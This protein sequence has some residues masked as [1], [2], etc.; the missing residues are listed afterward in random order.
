MQQVTALGRALLPLF[1]VALAGAP[2]WLGQPEWQWL[3]LPLMAL[4]IFWG[5]GIGPLRGALT[6]APTAPVTPSPM[7]QLLERLL[8]TW[9]HHV[10]SA[11]RQT[12]TAIG[13][14]SRSLAN[15][16]PHM[17]SSGTGPDGIAPDMM[18]ECGNALNAVSVSLRAM[19]QQHDRVLADISALAERTDALTTMASEVSSIAAQTNLLAINAAIEAAR[20]G[21][22]GQGFAVVAAEVRRLSQ[23]SSET[24][25]QMA[26]RV[27]QISGLMEGASQSIAQN[28]QRD[29]EQLASAAD[30]LAHWAQRLQRA[31]G[32]QARPSRSPVINVRK[33]LENVL[34]ALQFQDRV[35][36]IS[37]AVL[38]DMERLRQH[39]VGAEAQ[40]LPSVHDWMQALRATYSMEEQFSAH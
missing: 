31:N 7:H 38:D 40:S 35:S 32:D 17:T 36:Q 5:C 2:V 11:Q 27:A 23:R 30:Q 29:T 34:L 39:A 21:A 15:L 33:E 16:M 3:S 25:R 24:G 18:P 9:M 13:Q 22:S 19:N 26:E 20:A 1:C 12:E 28:R 37:Q 8:P 4:L 10:K 14:M 6:T